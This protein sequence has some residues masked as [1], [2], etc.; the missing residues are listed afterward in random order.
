VRISDPL[1]DKMS[2]GIDVK[3][4]WEG[5]IKYIFGHIK[6]KRSEEPGGHSY[7]LIDEEV[8]ALLGEMFT[9]FVEGLDQLGKDRD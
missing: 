9:I 4:K 1:G 7:L 5:I 2:E 3:R 6:L 8:T